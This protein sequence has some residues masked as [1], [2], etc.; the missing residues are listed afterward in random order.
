MVD[1]CSPSFVS[2]DKWSCRGGPI[3]F[4]NHKI[5]KGPEPKVKI[6]F[7]FSWLDNNHCEWLRS[8]PWEY[9]HGCQFLNFSHLGSNLSKCFEISR[10]KL[11]AK[12]IEL[13]MSIR[14]WFLE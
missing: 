13:E 4:Y 5:Q 9:N 14:I 11:V 7:Q 8:K 10:K 6:S 2:L 3:T 1:G 12:T